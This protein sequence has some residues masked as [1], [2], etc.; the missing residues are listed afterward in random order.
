LVGVSCYLEQVQY[1]TWNLAGAVLPRGYLDSV[2]A[3]GGTPVL[4]PPVG[5][6]GTDQLSR[7]DAL[8]IAGGPDID[9]ARYGQP[10]HARTGPPHRER[11]V[12]EFRMLEAALDAGV[13]VLGVCRGMQVLNIALGG[14]LRQHLPDLLGN[15]DHLPAPGSFGQIEVTIEPGCELAEVFGDRVLVHCHHH[16]GVDRLG[17]GLRPVGWAPDGTIE[18]VELAGAGFVVGVQWHPEENS[19]DHRLFSA[20]VHAAGR[21]RATV[22][23]SR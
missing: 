14:T 11:D 7:L 12:A 6:W 21:R 9:P 17:G 3:A 19:V 23:G 13:P 15:C 10:A 20:L 4:L 22:G 1:R 5:R 8:L 2:V 18:A 16:Q